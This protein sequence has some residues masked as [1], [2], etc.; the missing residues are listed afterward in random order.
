MSLNDGRFY[1]IS[2]SEIIIAF[3][4]GAE[5]KVNSMVKTSDMLKK[6]T[7]FLS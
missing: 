7:I 4:Y 6:C 3:Y 5:I 2:L 1:N